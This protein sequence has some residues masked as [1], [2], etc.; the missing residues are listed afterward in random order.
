MLV[1]LVSPA[2]KVQNIRKVDVQ[3][4]LNHGYKYVDKPADLETVELMSP[5][6]KVV[7]MK[8]DIGDYLNREGWSLL[9]PEPLAKDEKPEPLEIPVEDGVLANPEKPVEDETPVL[10]TDEAS[11]EEPESVTESELEPESVET[12]KAG[13]TEVQTEE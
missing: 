10:P 12:E 1:K 4:H 13:E 6:G 7:I 9:E 5:A 2:G 3:F 11:V 8:K